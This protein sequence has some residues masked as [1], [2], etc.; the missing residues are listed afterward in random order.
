MAKIM[1][2]QHIENKK[3]E[4]LFSDAQKSPSSFLKLSTINKRTLLRTL[5]TNLSHQ[6]LLGRIT[7]SLEEEVLAALGYMLM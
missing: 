5:G 2:R 4:Q 7:Q 3:L 6:R 1:Q